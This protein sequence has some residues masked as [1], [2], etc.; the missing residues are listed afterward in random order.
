MTNCRN[1]RLFWNRSNPTTF[2]S[3]FSLLA[4]FILSGDLREKTL[5]LL[6]VSEIQRGHR[7]SFS[8][9]FISGESGGCGEY[10]KWLFQSDKVWAAS[11]TKRWVSI[12]C[13][14]LFVTD[15][16]LN[17]SVPSNLSCD[18]KSQQLKS[19]CTSDEGKLKHLLSYFFFKYIACGGSSGPG[20]LMFLSHAPRFNLWCR[21][22]DL[23]SC[24]G[25]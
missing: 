21:S 4:L 7:H 24:L 3:Y 16:S 11:E 13:L 15:W 5:D 14:S 17:K 20:D 12:S 2:K 8:S 18:G 22:Y 9:S 6:R 23:V 10:Y 1:F 19:V 25:L